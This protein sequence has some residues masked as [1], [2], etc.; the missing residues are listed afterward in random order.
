[1]TG[2]VNGTPY[3]STIQYIFDGTSEY[4]VNC[5]R[6]AGQAEE[7][8]RGCEQILRTFTVEATIAPVTTTPS[9]SLPS[10]DWVDSP[11]AV[12]EDTQPATLSLGDTMTVTSGGADAGTIKVSKLKITIQPVYEFG[13][14]AAHGYFL[15]FTVIM[16]ASTYLDVSPRRLLH[17]HPERCT[18]RRRGRQRLGRGRSPDGHRRTRRRRTQDRAAGLRLAEQAREARLRPES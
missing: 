18:R 12:G 6:T 3:L 13:S 10:N 1:V 17:R 14:R 4:Y 9:P 2:T 8:E 15:I 7:I 11:P 5:Q 16:R